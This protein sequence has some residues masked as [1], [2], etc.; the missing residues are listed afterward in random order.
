MPRTDSKELMCIDVSGIPDELKLPRFM[1][2]YCHILLYT[3]S[4]LEKGTT[5]LGPCLAHLVPG[6]LSER[7]S[8]LCQP[9]YASC[10]VGKVG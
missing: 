7:F 1:V 2:V 6:H 3:N 4:I 10:S 5:S 9:H 8:V